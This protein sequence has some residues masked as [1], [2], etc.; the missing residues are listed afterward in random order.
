MAR[1]TYRVDGIER[2][3]LNSGE[4]TINESLFTDGGGWFL[5]KELSSSI[6]LGGADYKYLKTQT[7]ICRYFEFKIQK[8]FKLT[9][10]TIYTGRFTLLNCSFNDDLC[11]VT[12]AVET[13]DQYTCLLQN[14]DKELNVAQLTDTNTIWEVEN[15]RLIQFG[16][17]YGTTASPPLTVF[18]IDGSTSPADYGDV[19]EEFATPYENITPFG[20]NPNIDMMVYC[21]ELTYTACVNGV[22]Q[23]PNGTGWTLES[24]CSI[25]TGGFGFS[26]WWRRYDYTLDGITFD[27]FTSPPVT[28]YPYGVTQDVP[29]T[30]IVD[31]GLIGIYDGTLTPPNLTPPNQEIWFDLAVL[32]EFKETLRSKYVKG[33]RTL[34][35][36][37]NA[38]INNA[39][40]GGYSL[41][42]DFFSAALNPVTGTTNICANLQLWTKSDVANAQV[43][44]ADAQANLQA[45]DKRITLR[46]FLED[47]QIHFNVEWYIDAN[48]PKVIIFEHVSDTRP[49]VV[50]LDLT[51]PQYEA[52]LKNKSSYNYTSES[53]P[54]QEQWSFITASL[55]DFVGFPIDYNGCG[56]D[57]VNYN[58]S[59]IDTELD[60]LLGDEEQRSLDGFILVQ[61]DSIKSTDSLAQDG[62]IWAFFAPNMPLSISNLHKLFWPYQRKLPT[63]K[64]NN[65][66]QNFVSYQKLLQLNDLV[67]TLCNPN[68][69][70]RRKL[71]QTQYGECEIVAT[72]YNLTQ[73]T[74]EISLKFNL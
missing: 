9:T 63:G 73:E 40:G 37:G 54:I 50:D 6:R 7:D 46:E 72:S 14:W 27:A 31:F 61:P 5:R 25:S 29:G 35:D 66:T 8:I 17:G 48:N 70:D 19:I 1:Y 52:T 11:Q 44:E 55:P 10:E 49:Q 4:F 13:S 28:Y 68:S 22:P 58:T 16:L 20:G 21:R 36:V 41:S 59:Q 43:T 57:I 56:N 26:V 15:A 2:T 23:E 67:F 47:L 39:C 32:R 65:V 33:G 64:I 60:I 3:P 51:L 30:P 42:S 71:V 34:L 74:M 18:S 24:A 38:L 62:I 53:V 12:I 45:A 69:F